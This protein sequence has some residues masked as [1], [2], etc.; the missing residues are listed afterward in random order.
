VGGVFNSGILATG[1]VT[2][3]RFDYVEANADILERV[4]GI[5]AIAAE[6]GTDIATAALQFPLQN[7]AVASVLIGSADT[8]TLG[9]NLIS[10]TRSVEPM[11]YEASRAFTLR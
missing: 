6:A 2:G 1:A 9:R 7:P 4:G 5:E 8:S 10:L 3:A 11:L